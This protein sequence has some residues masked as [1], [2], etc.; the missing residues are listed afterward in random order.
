DATRLRQIVANLV[1]NA[2]K[3]T[4]KG[5]SITI[6]MRRID[7]ELELSVQDSGQGIT[8]EFLP[9]VFD[10][11]RQADSGLN[12]RNAGL[13]LGLAIARKLV[14]LHG[15]RITAESDGPGT[16]ATF[17]IRVPI[18]SVKLSAPTPPDGVAA[19]DQPLAGMSILVVEDE[20]DSR[21]LLCTLLGDAG[22]T[23]TQLASADEALKLLVTEQF[24]VVI[25]D[26]GMPGQ[27]GLAFMRELRKRG[28]HMPAVALTAYTRATDRS[29]ALNSGYDAHLG[30]PVDAH[31]MLAVV[32]SVVTR[33][34]RA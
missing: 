5:G 31:E 10:V 16:G 23:C 13:G 33:S 4:P 29:A 18:A 1:N 14:E 8:P 20:D 22:A 30:K 2:I 11:F 24:A 3:F 12:R 28:N 25:S 9:L 19:I 21:E 27:D 6:S 26:I 17:R 32:R 34:R 7:S 15:G